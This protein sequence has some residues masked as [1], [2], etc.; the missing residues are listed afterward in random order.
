MFG[1]LAFLIRGHMAISASGAGRRP[2]PRR[3]GAVGRAGRHHRGHRRGDAAAGRCPAGCGSR[4]RRGHRRRAG[5]V[6][7]AGRRAAPGRCRRSRREAGLRRR[8]PRRC[9][10]AQPMSISTLPTASCS[11]AS[12]AAA[13]RGERVV[14]Q[15]Q[16]RLTRPTRHG[17]GGDARRLTSSTR[18]RFSR[19]RL[20]GVDAARTGSAALAPIGAPDWSTGNV[21]AAVVGVHRDRRRAGDDG[22]RRGPSLRAGETSRTVSTHLGAIRTDG[23]RG[24]LGAVVDQ[25]VSANRPEASAAFPGEDPP[26]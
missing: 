13:V 17:A 26:W 18:R 5:P 25:V 11:T 14:V 9:W 1:G 4:G 23:R 12:C 3:P 21:V 6:G 19:C 15:R 7:R 24:V 20:Q 16:A 22:Q 2:R 10:A 8:P